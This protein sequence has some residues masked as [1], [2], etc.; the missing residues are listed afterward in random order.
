MRNPFSPPPK[1]EN[2]IPP[3]VMRKWRTM[4]EH[5]GDRTDLSRLQPQAAK[6]IGEKIESDWQRWSRNS[7]QLFP[8]TVKDHAGREVVKY[9]GDIRAAFQPWNQEPLRCKLA[10]LSHFDGKSYIEGKEPAHVRR[11]M[12]L[13][14]AGFPE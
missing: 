9:S 5:L 12:A 1:D 13:I 8:E 3:E 14:K 4:Q 2:A 11:S 6:V 10:T 7:G